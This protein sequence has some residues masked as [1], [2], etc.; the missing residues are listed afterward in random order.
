MPHLG[1]LHHTWRADEGRK[2][3]LA[4]GGPLGVVHMLRSPGSSVQEEAA[5][6]IRMFAFDG[7]RAPLVCVFCCVLCVYVRAYEYV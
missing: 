5:R 2:A 3:F 4:L 1:T 6:L 7:A